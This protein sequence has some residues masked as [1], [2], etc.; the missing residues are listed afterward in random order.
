ML[1]EED[2]APKIAKQ[3]TFRVLVAYKPV[4]YKK[5]VYTFF[6]RAIYENTSMKFDKKLRVYKEQSKADIFCKLR[7]SGAYCFLF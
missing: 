4:A 7:A 2:S 5:S 3:I 1:T 6:I